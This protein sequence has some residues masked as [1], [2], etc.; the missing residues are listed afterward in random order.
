MRQGLLKNVQLFNTGDLADIFWDTIHRFYKYFNRLDGFG[1][2]YERL[3]WDGIEIANKH[4][5]VF[6]S[7]A[8]VS[9][10]TVLYI[11]L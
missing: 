5:K 2:F 1:G 3:C 10:I 6:I 7:S 9:S 11:T 4:N 8:M